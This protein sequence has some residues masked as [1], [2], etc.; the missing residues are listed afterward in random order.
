LYHAVLF[1]D[2]ELKGLDPL[3]RFWGCGDLL[4][5]LEVARLGLERVGPRQTTKAK[6]WTVSFRLLFVRFLDSPN[7]SM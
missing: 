6:S 2:G 3:T 7:I 4:E 5:K 1:T